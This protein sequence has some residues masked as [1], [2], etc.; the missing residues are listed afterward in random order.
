MHCF[1]CCFLLTLGLGW[2]VGVGGKGGITG[3]DKK[4]FR[5]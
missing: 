4:L 2:G 5:V 3:D 1:L